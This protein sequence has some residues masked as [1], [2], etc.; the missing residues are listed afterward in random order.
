MDFGNRAGGVGEVAGDHHRADSRMARMFE[1]GFH[2]GAR[3]VDH[4]HQTD[5]DQILF[6]ILGLDLF[7]IIWHILFQTIGK[8]KHAQCI[9]GHRIV[10][11]E[12]LLAL[13]LSVIS[14]GLSSMP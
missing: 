4:A 14:R 1:R 10:G 6:Q 5:E 3:R 2:F 13:G 12:D 9:F 11:G 7:D 8:T